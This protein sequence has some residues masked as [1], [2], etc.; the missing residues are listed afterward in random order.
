AAG[1]PSVVVTR[2]GTFVTG[3]DR[4]ITRSSEHDTVVTED[5][6]AGNPRIEGRFPI[7]PYPQIPDYNQ[8]TWQPVTGNAAFTPTHEQAQ[9][10]E[11][12]NGA[13]LTIPGS[14]A[15]IP[16]PHNDDEDLGP[17]PGTGPTS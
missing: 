7:T 13:P 6:A 5:V 16:N 8:I 2:R 17:A 9:L 11:P 1:L 12:T 15:Q 14:A 10:D 4:R 3:P